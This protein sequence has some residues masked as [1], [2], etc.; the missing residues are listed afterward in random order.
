MLRAMG[1]TT[2][3]TRA[4]ALALFEASR[5]SGAGAVHVEVSGAEE[6][7]A[8]LAPDAT[9]WIAGAGYVPRNLFVKA[10]ELAAG[11]PPP[12]PTHFR[13]ELVGLVVDGDRAAIEMEL[14][15]AWDGGEYKQNYHHAIQVS[16]G[17]IVS[18]RQYSRN[19]TN[20]TPFKRLEF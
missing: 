10:H 20:T 11:G 1:S 7:D 16:D 13:M 12:E 8:L 19:A 2:E 17:K 14:D 5:R 15:T 9:W 3:E 18:L 6:I 4:V